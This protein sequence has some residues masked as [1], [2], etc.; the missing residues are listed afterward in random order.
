MQRK[1]RAQYFGIRLNFGAYCIT[2]KQNLGKIGSY[3]FQ[4]MRKKAKVV[5]TDRRTDKVTYRVA[6]VPD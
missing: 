5:P 3:S 2:Q 4:V 1:L 6:V